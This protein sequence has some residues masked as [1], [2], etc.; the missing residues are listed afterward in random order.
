MTAS[1]NISSWIR[2]SRW[3]KTNYFQC[4]TKL[5]SLEFS[6]RS[7][8]T[9]ISTWTSTTFKCWTQLSRKKFLK[10]WTLLWTRSSKSCL[11]KSNSKLFSRTA[12]Q[13]CVQTITLLSV[14]FTGTNFSFP[15]TSLS[16]CKEASESTGGTFF[17][18]PRMAVKW[19]LF[20]SNSYRI[21]NST[22]TSRSFSNSTLW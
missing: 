17:T 21:P 1:I 11:G 2:S 5:I 16:L 9:T 19:M 6:R 20:C 10:E 15:K 14:T 4:L 7:I 18:Q 8:C 13:P 3:Q 22:L 12:Q